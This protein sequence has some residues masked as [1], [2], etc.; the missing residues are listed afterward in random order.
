MSM[1]DVPGDNDGLAVIVC[2]HSTAAL[3]RGRF[4]A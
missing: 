3:M 4:Q 2:G 1:R